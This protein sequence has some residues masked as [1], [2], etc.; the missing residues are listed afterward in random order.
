MA[1]YD[2]VL[3]RLGEAVIEATLTRWLKKEGDTVNEEDP[4]AEIATDKVDTEVT[5]PVAGV[6]AKQLAAEGDVIPVG[7]IIATLEVKD[8]G[9]GT[10][11]EGRGTKD[12]GRGTKDEIDSKVAFQAEESSKEAPEVADSCEVPSGHE[13]LPHDHDEGGTRFYSPLVRSIA[14]QENISFQELGSIP[15]TG[16]N[17]RLTKQ[18]L[19]NYV[20]KRKAS[21]PPLPAQSQVSQGLTHSPTDQVIEM[22]RVRQLIATH[23]VKSV[24]TSPHVT[25]F[26]EVDMTPIVRWREKHKDSFFQRE[27]MKLTYTPII[28]EAIAKAVRDVPM[29]NVSVDGTR[30]LVHKRINVGMAVAL[31]NSNLIV[32]V[33]RDADQKS[34]LGITKMVN[35]LADRARQNKLVPDEIAGGTVSLTNL[36]SFGTLMG[37]P[38]INQ[39]QAAIV[40]IGSIT[41]RPVVIETPEGDTI[42]IRL[43][44][45][46]S[47]TFDH[48]VVDG[49]MAGEFLNK[50]VGHLETFDTNQTL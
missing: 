24:Q 7:Q 30:V 22:D 21:P 10:K 43:M 50:M 27:G 26:I 14:V 6:F 34:L 4:I 49:A 25:S 32:P 29:I 42:G 8:E 40:A 20:E 33:I 5:S 15:G 45:F 37:T 19:L 18:D 12:E 47:V 48:R 3:P 35:D 16:K 9:R 1:T 41:K 44:M 36:G 23:M 38:I 13:D 11:D 2:I 46:L 28:I 31:P 17:D 39:P